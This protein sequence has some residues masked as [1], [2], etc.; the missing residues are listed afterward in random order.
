MKRVYEIFIF[1]YFFIVNINCF[2]ST[3]VFGHD[4]IDLPPGLDIVAVTQP[5]G[6]FEPGTLIID[7]KNDDKNPIHVMKDRISILESIA[8]QAQALA[9]EEHAKATLLK[10]WEDDR[11]TIMRWVKGA[12]MAIVFALIFFAII[13]IFVI[14]AR[15][16]KSQPKINQPREE[17]IRKELMEYYWRL[18]TICRKLLLFF[19][20]LSSIPAVFV[21]AVVIQHPTFVDIVKS[22]SPIWPIVASIATPLIFFLTISSGVHERLS[23]FMKS[24]VA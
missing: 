20:C 13:Y 15:V 16:E 5:G 22:D 14:R 10:G 8:N 23:K 4:R 11:T 21:A 12:T 3:I 19:L 9:K 18:D 7:I 6:E 17:R 2:A 1:I 24:P